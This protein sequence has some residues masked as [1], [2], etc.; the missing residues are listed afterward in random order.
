MSAVLEAMA[1][2][3]AGWAPAELAKRLEISAPAAQQ[4]LARAKRKG[5]VMKLGPAQWTLVSR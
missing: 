3:R 4:A 5:F 1:E 2:R